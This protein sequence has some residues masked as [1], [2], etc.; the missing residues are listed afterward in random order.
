MNIRLVK[1]GWEREVGDALAAAGGGDL[2]IICPFI[3]RDALEP[4]LSGELKVIQVITRF[5]CA[6]FAMGVSDI[7]ALRKLLEVGTQ[8]RGIQ[9]L[10]AKLFL[11]GSNRAIV[12]SANLTKSAMGKNL[13]CGVVV[14]EESVLADCRKYFDS[15]W[16]QGKI[17]T[18][19]NLVDWETEIAPHREV[20]KHLVKLEKLLDHGAE[21]GSVAESPIQVPAVSVEAPRAQGEWSDTK[22]MCWA[23]W[24]AL[25]DVL[26]KLNEAGNPVPGDLASRSDSMIHFAIGK[27]GFFVSAQIFVKKPKI[28][29][30][31]YIY[32]NNV[33]NFYLLL[34]KQREDIKRELG[35]SLKWEKQRKTRRIAI[36][37]ND[38]NPYDR[39]DWPRQHMWLAKRLN[40]LHRVFAPRVEA[41]KLVDGKRG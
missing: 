9:D 14:E 4:F 30:Q 22:T 2:R 3:K 25:L 6:D 31:I 24:S 27:H 8:V 21:V 23:Y 19:E 26:K 39:G 37:L 20:R 13:E 28:K 36:Y 15:L 40:D 1:S 41:L 35:Y 16:L 10:H 33:E 5:K 12:T 18:E 34:Q 11:F 38:A 29:S 32:E 17:L 7:E